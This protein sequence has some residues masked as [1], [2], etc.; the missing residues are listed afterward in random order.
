MIGELAG[1]GVGVGV[2]EMDG[3]GDRERVAVG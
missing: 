1:F 3:K 2:I